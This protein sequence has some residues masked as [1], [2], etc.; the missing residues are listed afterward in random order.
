MKK[1]LPW[2]LVPLAAWLGH[3]EA[4]LSPAPATAA[5]PAKM[6]APV[7]EWID[8]SVASIASADLETLL[9]RLVPLQEPPF[10]H[11]K[12]GEFR[13]ICARLAELD[14]VAALEWIGKNL[15]DDRWST[16]TTVLTEWAL[17]DSGAAWAF[18][19][20]AQRVTTTA[21]PLPAACF[22]EDRDLFMEWFRRVRQPMP[23]GD[24]AWLLLAERYADELQ[25]I[26]DARLKELENP[27]EG[28][29][30]DFVPLFHLLAKSRAAKDP[31]GAF[32][33]ASGLAPSVRAGAVRGVLE[34]W[35]L[36]DPMAT[37]AKLLTL[38]RKMADYSVVGHGENSIGA[39][40]LKGIAEK[41]PAAAMKM[42]RE[43]TGNLDISTLGG[44]DVMRSVLSSAVAGGE[45][46]PVEAFRLVNSA[47][48]TASNLP[49]NV[50]DRMWFGMEPELLEKAA[51][52]LLGEP[53]DQMRDRALAGIAGA[54]M[55]DAPDAAIQFISA[56]EDDK[57]RSTLFAG[58]FDQPTGGS[59][60][61]TR[62]AEI[63]KQIPEKDRAAVFVSFANQ[64]G[65]RTAGDNCRSMGASE[66]R[67]DLIAPLMEESTAFTRSRSGRNDH[68]AGMG[69]A[70][71][72]V[73]TRLGGRAF[74]SRRAVGRLRRRLRRLDFSGS[75]GRRR[76]ADRATCGAGS[77]RRDPAAGPAA[78]CQRSGK[79][80]G[81][82]GR[83]RPARPPNR[84]TACGAEIVVRPSARRGPRGL[85]RLPFHPATRGGGE[86]CRTLFRKVNDMRH[87]LPFLV[88]VAAFFVARQWRPETVPAAVPEASKE[89]VEHRTELRGLARRADR[90]AG[91]EV[92]AV[93]DLMRLSRSGG[94]PASE[95]GQL[96]LRAAKLDP[97]G[98]WDWINGP[99]V[100]PN[101]RSSYR[102]T[103]AG[104]WF[105]K[106]PEAV[107]SRLAATNSD[108]WKIAG[109]LV[110][111]FFS[112]DPAESAVARKHLDALVA[113]ASPSPTSFY[114]PRD[115]GNAALL[116]SLP[117]GRARDTLTRQY[118]TSWLEEDVVGGPGM[119]E[120][121]ARYHAGGN[122]GELRGAG[123][124]PIQHQPGNP[125]CSR[126]LGSGTKLIP[127][128]TPASDRLWWS[129]WQ[130]KTRRPLS[131]GHR[132]TSPPPRSPPPREKWF[133]SFSPATP[134]RPAR[135]WPAC[136]RET[137]GIVPRRMLPW[138]G[139]EKNLPPQSIGGSR[140][141]TPPKPPE[142]AA[143]P[144][145]AD[146][147]KLGS[148]PT[149][150]PC[151][152]GWQTR[153][154]LP[155]SGRWPN[156]HSASGPKKNPPP[157]STG[158]R[159]CRTT[160]G[161]PSSAPFIANGPTRTRPPPRRLSPAGRTRLHP[162]PPARSPRY[163]SAP[164]RKVP[165][166]GPPPCR[167]DQRA[168]PRSRACAGTPTSKSS[169]AAPSRPPCRNFSTEELASQTRH[170]ASF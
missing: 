136:R 18:L 142:A 167:P 43:V 64:Y 72:C 94:T 97:E 114:L 165:S 169:S 148:G 141:S 38:D 104:I 75:A 78:R 133:P 11:E 107:L 88:A 67:P 36:T 48:G 65:N 60:Q 55:Q 77:R 42:L 128:P 168:M 69:R 76:L 62:Q 40:I 161:N 73:G 131:P 44:I 109:S 27:K 35:A 102:Q 154:C 70:G 37:W 74:R 84:S 24:P 52:G 23:N 10:T 32:E 26:A 31:A 51:R 158:P 155:S 3:R 127:P 99:D 15:P 103:V 34:A 105:P 132:K 7:P 134:I 166:G 120:R 19:P 156:P 164:T 112:K 79:R 100:S 144:L 61:G 13:L 170:P 163:G 122:H 106:D 98:T 159:A 28:M 150:I 162:L 87:L 157:P 146:W 46:D 118:A 49:L 82:G 39:G 53:D 5:A 126:G 68:R 110:G 25:E 63:L 125:S 115:E 143:F 130:R 147:A 92:G 123:G 54:W 93:A 117:E 71:P 22:D 20:P 66:I 33:W 89:R 45:M 90:L 138:R 8:A 145:P 91:Q 86:V 149:P 56:I 83:D 1:F 2:L 124:N 160:A 50:V 9:Q 30:F 85:S 95:L 59:A 129:G 116:L 96:V 29:R 119:D 140:R 58:A 101:H 80:V 6:P 152:P 137:C 151:A 81:L 111:F 121:P 12:S 21:L 108:D 17:L 4:V 47:K 139:V 57:L 41:D 153:P 113:L 16:R 14:P 135:S